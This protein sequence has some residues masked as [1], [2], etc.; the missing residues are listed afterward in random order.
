MRAV[1]F[2]FRKMLAAVQ[3]GIAAREHEVPRLNPMN[4]RAP[5]PPPLVLSSSRQRQQG[6][7]Q[8]AAFG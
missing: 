5:H 6:N 2:S 8:L 7:R 3:G 1:A 4:D